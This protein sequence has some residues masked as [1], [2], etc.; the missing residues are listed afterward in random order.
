MSSI[1]YYVR[2]WDD[3]GIRVSL[4]SIFGR[5]CLVTYRKYGDRVSQ[6]YFHGSRASWIR[7]DSR[8][9]S[10]FPYLDN[11]DLYFEVVGD[12][13][14]IYPVYGFVLVSLTVFI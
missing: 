6:F 4:K 12:Y 7:G 13:L 1:V 3:P 8:S 11:E 14:L 5:T 2:R 10:Y 9:R